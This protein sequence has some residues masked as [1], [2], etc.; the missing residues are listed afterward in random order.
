MLPF[1]VTWTEVLACPGSVQLS[2]EPL[3]TFCLAMLIGHSGLVDELLV[4]KVTN[5]AQ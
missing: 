2:Q 3:R 4:V 1:R 5:R